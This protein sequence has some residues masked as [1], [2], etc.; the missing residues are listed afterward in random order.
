MQHLVLGLGWILNPIVPGL[1][2]ASDRL[3]LSGLSLRNVT[4]HF[5]SPVDAPKNLRL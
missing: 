4:G 3:R 1:Q 2:K 5:W